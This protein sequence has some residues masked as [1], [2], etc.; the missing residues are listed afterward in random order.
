MGIKPYDIWYTMAFLAHLEKV[1][2]LAKW[3]R[4]AICAHQATTSDMTID[5]DLIHLSVPP[6][7]IMLRYSNMKAYGNH[8]WIDNDQNSMLVTYDCGVAPIFQQSQGSE[9]EVLGAIQYVGTLK[10]ILQL[11]YGLISSP[12]TLF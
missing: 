6:S 5:P 9:D 8:L 2:E 12:I 11:E 4:K 10:E 1:E 3:V 7:F